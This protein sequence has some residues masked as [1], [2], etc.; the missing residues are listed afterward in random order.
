MDIMNILFFIF[1]SGVA[2]SYG[3]GMRGTII[4]GEKGAMLPG[5]RLGMLMAVF[6]GSE[7]LASSPWM[8]AGVGALG[9]Y[10][11][12]NMTYADTLHLTMHEKNPPHFVK[13]MLGGIF[14]RGGI[15]FGLF[16]GFTG[17]MISALAGF[18]KLWQILVFFAL[19]PVFALIFFNIFN[20]PF[21]PE[22]NIFPRLYFSIKRRETWG[23]LLGMLIEVT[24]FSAVFKDWSTLALTGGAF[25][26]G[27]VGWV[28]AQLLQIRV[29][30]PAKNGK[31]LFEKLSE[32]K[33]VD[34]WKIMECVLGA[35]GG[36]GTAITFVV[37]KPLFAD[38]FTT[39][40]VNGFHSYI[41]ESKVTYLLFIIYAVILFADCLQYFIKPA[42]NKKYNKKLLKMK[43]ITKDAY[44]EAVSIAPEDSPA[45]IRYRKFCAH[46]EFA[47][48][49]IIPLLLSMLGAHLVAAAVAFPVVMLVL[50]QEA[51]EKCIKFKK[52]DTVMKLT[53]L[54]PAFAVMVLIAISKKAML[55]S[56]TM[57]MY[58]VFYE[59]CFYLILKLIEHDRIFLSN[60]EKTVHSYFSLCCVLIMIMTIFI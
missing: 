19:L 18:Y 35:L 43:L 37:S 13:N 7:V 9:M 54:L 20:K 51:T 38:K 21:D 59:L 40:D 29:L 6:S 2:V 26:S 41:T 27:A 11:G 53:Y 49:S 12:G 55:T 10:C 46:S 60:S 56:V 33:A 14:L 32:K 47:I 24:I 23:G 57:L 22:N 50:C 39:I 36:M 34:A 44:K 52:D 17:L 25:L 42:R 3:W 48:Y 28:M 15:W 8:L 4:G 58:T 45:Y 31:R 30:H 16:G 5:A 1:F